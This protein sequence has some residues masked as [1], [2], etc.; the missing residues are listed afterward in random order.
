MTKMPDTGAEKLERDSKSRLL[1]TSRYYLAG[2]AVIPLLLAL[3]VY[4]ISAGHI[5]SVKRTQATDRFVLSM[6]ELLSTMQDAETGQRGYLLTGSE[7]YLAPYIRAK[8]ELAQRFS[9]MAA[10]A[11]QT[12]IDRVQ[13]NELRAAVEDKMQE[14]EITISF[15]RSGGRN[16][17]M[18]EIRTDRGQQVMARIRRLIGQL[19][20]EQ[21]QAYETGYAQ[22]V[23][24]QYYLDAALGVVVVISVVLLVFAFHFGTLYARERDQTEAQIRSLNEELESRVQERT[25]E[26]EARTLESEAQAVKLERSNADLAQ[27]AS[28]ASHDLQEPLRMV[29]SY[30]GMLSRKYSGTL[31]ETART[32]IQYAIGGATRMQTL[33]SDLLAYSHAGTQAIT[34]QVLPAE[35]ICKQATENLRLVIQENSAIVHFKD[36]P[37]VEV[38][39]VKMTQVVQNLL[40]NAIKFRKP[41]VLPEI[42]ISAERR[43]SDWLFSVR[44]N[45]IGFDS[46]YSD[47]IFQ[48]FQRLHS[49]GRYP[50][51]GI[52]L[53]ICRR[54][55]EHHGG[56]LWAESEPGVGS[57]FYFTLPFV[58]EFVRKERAATR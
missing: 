49:V 41:D 14:L 23:R 37:P 27:F 36:L 33:V 10:L 34:K 2:L 51:N 40:G 53:S 9:D 50:G 3:V 11:S 4:F 5:R 6:D 26:L 52:G 45:G 18:A 30:M 24:R 54:I 15:Y 47:R 31:D 19:K 38:D 46:K 42:T 55:V 44:D 29:A 25:A 22:Q 8:G 1:Q 43:A 16:A 28:I 58:A 7:L 39:Q 21:A 57:T 32:Y 12:G 20:S 35:K 17:A 13:L 56:N 48:V